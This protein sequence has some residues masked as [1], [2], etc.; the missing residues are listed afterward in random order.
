MN[1]A[2]AQ[3]EHDRSD[4]IIVSF[5]PEWHEKI[6]RSDFSV[7]IRK[8]TPAKVQ[9]SFIYFHVNAPVGKISARARILSIQKID[10]ATALELSSRIGID[11]S[12]I[13]KYIGPA[14]SVG[15]YF[16]ENIELPEIEISTKEIQKKCVY[17]PP[18]SF[19]FLSREG[20]SVIDQ[21]CRF[22]PDPTPSPE[23]QDV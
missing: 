2:K 22:K 8:R 12:L 1:T 19:L 21:L 13:K 16:I 15:A 18:Q 23:K 9:P 4:S 17:T 11:R 3:S 6:R 10:T 7:I 20:K 5:D 14:A